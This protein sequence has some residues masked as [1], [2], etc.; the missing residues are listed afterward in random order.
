MCVEVLHLSSAW[1]DFTE[2]SLA[3][4]CSAH[5]VFSAVKW[6]EDVRE[7]S[8]QLNHPK[9]M[10]KKLYTPCFH[11]DEVVREGSRRFDAVE[12]PRSSI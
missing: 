4:S 2:P 11:C 6:F 3:T 5:L 12:P 8:M 7:G 1:F 10:W 9:L